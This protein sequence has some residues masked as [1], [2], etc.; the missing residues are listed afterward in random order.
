M[1][2]TEIRNAVKKKIKKSIIFKEV[3]HY[4]NLKIIMTEKTDEAMAYA[5][6]LLKRRGKE[7]EIIITYRR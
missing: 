4:V 1:I 5:N 3:T 7:T 6:A 2:V